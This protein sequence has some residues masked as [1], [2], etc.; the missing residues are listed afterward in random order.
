MNNDDS[1]KAL[2]PL[3]PSQPEVLLSEMRLKWCEGVQDKAGPSMLSEST[4][5]GGAGDNLFEK[6]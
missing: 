5:N 4:N 1:N 3:G 6:V 2:A